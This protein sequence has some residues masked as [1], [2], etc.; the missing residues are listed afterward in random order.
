MSDHWGAFLRLFDEEDHDGPYSVELD[1]FAP[2]PRRRKRHG[3]PQRPVP[4]GRAVTVNRETST[5]PDLRNAV[6]R[7]G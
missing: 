7:R 4:F 1:R 2:S 6:T 3:A 5:L